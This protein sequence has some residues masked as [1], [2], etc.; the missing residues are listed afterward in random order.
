[1]NRRC[2]SPAAL[3]G[4]PRS[5]LVPRLVFRT[6]SAGASHTCGIASG[7]VAYAGADNTAGELGPGRLSHTSRGR[8]A[9]DF[10]SLSA[11]DGFTCGVTHSGVAYCWA[12]TRMD[13]SAVARPSGVKRLPVAAAGL[14]F[15]QVSAGRG[16]ACGIGA[17]HAAYCWGSNEDGQLGRATRLVL[18]TP[19]G[20]RAALVRFPERRMVHTCGVTP[21]APHTAGQQYA[22]GQLGMVRETRAAFPSAVVHIHEFVSLSAGARHTCGLT[23]AGSL[24]L[25]DDSVT[26]WG[27]GRGRELGATRDRRRPST[28]IGDGRRFHTCG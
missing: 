25:G 13:T 8:E 17:D 4:Q 24:L 3:G 16:H 2:S 23:A 10:A 1:M 28:R 5:C 7:G 27:R 26:S 21:K 14:V 19:P 11:G 12:A 18:A 9:P 22:A 15:L 6:V 20:R